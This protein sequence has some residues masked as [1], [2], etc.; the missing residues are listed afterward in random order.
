MI[1]VVRCLIEVPGGGQ[2]LTTVHITLCTQNCSI[3]T[4]TRVAQ[5]GPWRY[6]GTSYSD[7]TSSVC[8]A[9][10]HHSDGEMPPVLRILRTPA[11][12]WVE[13]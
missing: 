11:I 1:A 3:E 8:A 5:G 12:D 13:T 4:S 9:K 10:C 2:T 7:L 6:L